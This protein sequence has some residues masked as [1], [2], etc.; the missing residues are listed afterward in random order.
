[1]PL[2]AVQ[3]GDELRVKPGEKIPVDG[4][5]VEG[6]S[7]VDESML[8]G[9]PVPIE[10]EAGARVSAGTVNGSGSLL[11]R[12]EK[13]GAET[14]LAQIVQ[15]VAQ[16]QRSR[17]PIQRLADAVAGWFV[18]AVVLVAV[19]T[20][21]AWMVWGPEPRFAY[22]LV[23]AVAVLIIACP[24]ALGLA[25]PM[26]IMVG[27]GRGAT[28]GVLV[29][30]AEA[31][32]RLGKVDTLVVDK[33]GTLTEGRPSVVEI[34]PAPG[35]DVARVLALASALESHSEHPLAGAVMRAAQEK[36]ISALEVV[37][38][39]SVPG[40]GARGGVEGAPAL[41]GK[42]ALL[43]GAGVADFDAV[44]AGPQLEKGRT[45]IWLASAGK[46]AGALALA[47]PIKPTTAQAVGALH[48]QGVRLVMLTGDNS[49]TA[50]RVAGE[51]GIDD[52][53]AE[54]SPADKQA[55][56]ADLKKGG[57]VVA[58]AGDGVNDAPALAAA[59][60]G[61]AM[62]TGTDVAM[63]SAG[64]TLVKGDL[65]GIAHAIALSRATM[66]NIRQNLVFAFLYNS[67]GVPLAAGVLYPFFGVLLSPIV[68]SAA[69][70]L[71]SV[72]VVGNALRLRR[73]RLD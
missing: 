62:G 45:V 59:D 30:D 35:W 66:R 46:L 8:T 49:Q 12:A 26:S 55:R 14:L 58:M 50:A 51:L 5:V 32:E 47:D 1:L 2:D 11:M 7:A 15:M 64:V 54:V 4:A 61:I 29:K 69:M 20:F 33:T 72:S 17:A 25:T 44:N 13:V 18:P 52:F 57:A 56:V 37:E 39:E 6:R 10:K 73:A 27:V 53:V 48:A 24:C 36:G 23:N 70:A 28:L 65:R 22:A 43:E 34:L 3:P 9:E 38:F 21:S 60:V 19:L 63:Q 40:G 71:S 16:A 67:L 42:R 41:I 31:L 68:A